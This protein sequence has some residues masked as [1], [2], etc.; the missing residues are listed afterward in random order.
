MLSCLVSRAHDRSRIVDAEVRAIGA[1]GLNNAYAR[2]LALHGSPD[3]ARLKMQI[4]SEF[5][6]TANPFASSQSPLRKDARSRIARNQK[7]F[8]AQTSPRVSGTIIMDIE[9]SATPEYDVIVVGSGIGGLSAGALASRYGKRVLVCEAHSIPGGAAHSFDR[10]GYTFDSGPSLWSGLANASF[11]PLRQVFD[12]IGENPEWKQYESWVMYTEAG[13]FLARVGDPK[14]WKA[15]LAQMGEGEATVAQWDRLIDFIEPLQRAVLAVPP[16]ALRGDLG[17]VFTVLPYLGAMADPRIGLRAYL[18]EGPWSNV[19][20]A[21]GITDKFLWNW[22]DFLAFAFS[23]LPSNGTVAAAMVYML[24]ELQKP[25]AKMDYPVGGSSAVVQALVRGL[26]RNGGE[27]RLRAPVAELLVSK[28]GKCAGVKLKNGEILRA[29]EAVISNAPVWQTSAL[30]PS[31]AREKVQEQLRSANGR[32]ARPLDEKTPATPSFVHLHLGIRGDGLSE[33]ALQ[34]IHHIAVPQWDKLTAPQ[35]TVFVSIPSLLDPSLAPN[36][37]H[38]VHA[39]LPATEPYEIWEGLD[40]K[41]EKYKELKRERVAPLYAAIEKFI[42]DIRERTEVEL[43][44]SPLTHERYLRR[45]RGS[46]GPEL[47]AGERDFPGAKTPIDNLFVCGD[48]TWPGIGV[49][50]VAGSGIAAVHSFVGVGRQKQ[51]LEDL[52]QTGALSA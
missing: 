10:L 30:L 6:L 49:P 19:L 21:A 4:F 5:L 14:A 42:P 38:V 22:F 25:G 35:S 46:Y 15:T 23:G 41:S 33:R 26:E 34:S 32:D 13:D 39:Y 28:D 36:G 7:R 17:A 51:L 48:S 27:L 29:R 47:P 11:N 44:G 12:A 2:E 52:R 9:S 24:A 40:R 50:A 20:H 45:F 3:G 31:S 43:V 16:L 18:L 1:R 8:H 37:R